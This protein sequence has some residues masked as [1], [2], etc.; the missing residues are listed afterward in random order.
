MPPPELAPFPATSQ[1]GLSGFTGPYPSTSLDEISLCRVFSCLCTNNCIV[2]IPNRIEKCQGLKAAIFC[3]R[4]TRA[5][6][7][8]DKEITICY[9]VRKEYKHVYIAQY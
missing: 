2:S 3:A 8:L 7:N 4:E 5:R 6:A 1:G 9:I